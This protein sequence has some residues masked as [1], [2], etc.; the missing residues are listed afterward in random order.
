MSGAVTIGDAAW[1][2]LADSLP[3]LVWRAGPDGEIN[4][5]IGQDP[6]DHENDIVVDFRRKPWITYSAG[7]QLGLATADGATRQAIPPV[8]APAV[9]PNYVNIVVSPD[10]SWY[11]AIRNNSE[12][13]VGPIDETSNSRCNAPV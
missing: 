12:L 4:T 5:P 3:S 10:A 11:A 7:N 6:P 1:R 13:V 9:A 2:A 8:V